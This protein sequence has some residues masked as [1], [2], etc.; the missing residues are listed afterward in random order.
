MFYIKGMSYLGVPLVNNKG[1]GDDDDNYGDS[2]P[3]PLLPCIQPRCTTPHKA[4][5]P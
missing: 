4:A 2:T 3:L 1:E 5:P